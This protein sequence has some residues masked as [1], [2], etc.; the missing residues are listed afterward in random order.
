MRSATV[1]LTDARRSPLN[2][3]GCLFVPNIRYKVQMNTRGHPESLVASQPGNLNA[4]KQGVHSPRLIVA[5][6]AEVVAELTRSFEFSPTEQIAV[7]EAARC[8]AVLEAIDRDIDQR[9]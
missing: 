9:G 4:V 8:I 2:L 1:V 6:A 3:R 7:G 5:R